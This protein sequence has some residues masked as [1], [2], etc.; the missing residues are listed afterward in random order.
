MNRRGFLGALSAL[1]A[2]PLLPS[3]VAVNPAALEPTI[4]RQT[5]DASSYQ[6]QE[7]GLAFEFDANDLCED[8]DSIQRRTNHVMQAVNNALRRDSINAIRNG[9]VL[10][11]LEARR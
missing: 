5:W 8:K 4:D 2:A 7:Y 9:R 1:M 11:S 6:W 3:V 10:M